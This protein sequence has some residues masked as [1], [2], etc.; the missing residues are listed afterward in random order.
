MLIGL[1]LLATDDSFWNPVLSETRPAWLCIG[2]H[3]LFHVPSFL[4]IQEAN[5][6]EK[7]CQGGCAIVV[8]EPAAHRCH[9]EKD[10]G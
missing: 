1:S 10:I 6:F 7:S 4:D 5:V 3:A 8:A 2:F 9:P